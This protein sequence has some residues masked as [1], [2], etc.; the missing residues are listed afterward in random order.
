VPVTLLEIQAADGVMD[1]YLHTPEDATAP[2]PVVIMYPD[3]GG[4]R[5]VAQEAA[6]RFA[7]AGYAV[8]LV[9]YFYRSGRI[10]FDLS[11]DLGDP[12]ARSRMMATIG[13]APPAGVVRDTEALLDALATRDDLRTDKVGAIGYCRGGYMAFTLAG[14]IPDRIAAAASIHGGGIATDDPASP[15]RRADAITAELYFGIAANDPS[16][17]PEQQKL[18]VAALDAA[19]VRYEIDNVDAGHGFT[20]RDH[21]AYDAAA[22]ELHVAKSTA[23]FARALPRT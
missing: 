16:C 21:P 20:M 2:L 12:E 9:N 1:V 10:S 11:R 23:L 18:L 22:T 14:A 3:A 4:I 15:H 6:A 17:T 19:G 7:A 8:A 5:P 13:E